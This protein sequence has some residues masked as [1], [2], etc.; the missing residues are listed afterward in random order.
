MDTEL[1]SVHSGG[2]NLS[3]F[4]LLGGNSHNQQKGKENP[5]KVLFNIRLSDQ[6]EVEM[7]HVTHGDA[8]WEPLMVERTKLWIKGDDGVYA[9]ELKPG[10]TLEVDENDRRSSYYAAV[11]NGIVIGAFR[12][13]HRRES[14]E[15][16]RLFIRAKENRISSKDSTRILMAFVA[17]M[18]LVLHARTYVY[19]TINALFLKK[20]NG[21][22]LGINVER[23]GPDVSHKGK[24][25]EDIIF[26]P[27]RLSRREDSGRQALAA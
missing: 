23:T 11:R 3:S 22:R 5:M 26:V 17:T 13:I 24:N 16:S 1:F 21:R 2:S 6:T 19:A 12:L 10:E 18:K 9:E 25:D 27:V 14:D 20:I 7:Y 8:L 15:V 4:M